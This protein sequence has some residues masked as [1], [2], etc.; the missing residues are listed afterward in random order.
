M[1]PIHLLRRLTTGDLLN[2]QSPI[3]STSTIL[4]PRVSSLPRRLAATPTPKLEKTTPKLPSLTTKL[5]TPQPKTKQRRPRALATPAATPLLSSPEKDENGSELTGKITNQLTS[6]TS[7]FSTTLLQNNSEQLFTNNYLMKFYNNEQCPSTL[8]FCSSSATSSN[9]NSPFHNNTTHV[10]VNFPLSQQQ[11]LLGKSDRMSKEKQKFFRH[12][13]FSSV[14]GGVAGT[15]GFGLQKSPNKLKMYSS[16][17]SIRAD[18][19]VGRQFENVMEMNGPSDGMDKQTVITL[20]GHKERK[21]QGGLGSKKSGDGK[22]R[23][24][25]SSSNSSSSCSSSDDENNSSSSDSSSSSNG[26][27]SSSSSSYS[28]TST[29]SG[30]SSDDEHQFKQR[31]PHKPKK[32]T[33]DRDKNKNSAPSLI[34]QNSLASVTSS[35]HSR[36]SWPTTTNASKL[37]NGF[38]Q[39][40]FANNKMSDCKEWGFAAEAKKQIDVFSGH[41]F[42][43]HRMNHT[44]GTFNTTDDDPKQP[45]SNNCTKSTQQKKRQSNGSHGRH[46]KSQVKILNDA[47]SPIFTT[48]DLIRSRHQQQQLQRLSSTEEIALL[49]QQPVVLK[50][51][52]RTY[53]DYEKMLKL[54]NALEQQEKTESIIPNHTSATM[55]DEIVGSRMEK[56]VGRKS[57]LTNASPSTNTEKNNY[58]VLS[59]DEDE[60]ENIYLSPSKLVK[61]AINNKRFEPS[62]NNDKLMFAASPSAS[63]PP[64]NSSKSQNSFGDF[65]GLSAS[66]SSNAIKVNNSHINKLGM[67][68]PPPYNN[69]NHSIMGKKEHNCHHLKLLLFHF[70][71]S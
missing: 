9:N 45:P 57:T 46:R 60:D 10:P 41:S 58:S 49:Q 43:N 70:F 27:S 59:S 68:E 48:S 37:I 42:Q 4:T 11:I 18:G 22:K 23:K 34:E 3:P 67:S 32:R 13:V 30:S 20:D 47:L 52:R 2:A 7:C 33:D 38:M 8:S 64:Q 1:C 39:S 56:T 31:T 16:S 12:S 65:H 15:N 44:F 19:T 26:S 6:S 40:P 61:R 50:E 25:E 54:K 66:S 69:I 53:K 71:F 24:Q 14:R 51:T 29:S 62:S 17:E 35:S 21:Q 36:L 55:S 5:S 63:T 28:T